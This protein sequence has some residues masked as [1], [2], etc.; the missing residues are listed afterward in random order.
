MQHNNVV[1]ITGG[2][3]DIGT[4]I[5][6]ELNSSYKHVFALDLISEKDGNAWKKNSWMKGIRTL[7]FATWT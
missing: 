7:I 5:A 3:G 6:R 2:T 4:A 1:L